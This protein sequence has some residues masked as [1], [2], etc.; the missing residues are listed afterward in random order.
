MEDFA[1]VFFVGTRLCKDGDGY[2]E[3]LRSL[4]RVVAVE[5]VRLGRTGQPDGST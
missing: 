5:Q 4:E 1:L 3:G 2:G